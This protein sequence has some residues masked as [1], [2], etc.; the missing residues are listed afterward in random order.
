MALALLVTVV[1]AITYSVAAWTMDIGKAPISLY[2]TVNSCANARVCYC[3]GVFVVFVA[4]VLGASHLR[5]AVWLASAAAMWDMRHRYVFCGTLALLLFVSATRPLLAVGIAMLCALR[6]VCRLLIGHSYAQK[7]STLE[8]ILEV[9]D[10][11]LERKE[12]TNRDFVLLKVSA[13][14]E[15][16]AV[17]AMVLFY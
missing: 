8:G 13:A 5:E 12:G 14:A 15:L 2:Y 11:K 16:A 9:G 7:G 6:L 1:L 10:Q 17:F 4:W 3:V